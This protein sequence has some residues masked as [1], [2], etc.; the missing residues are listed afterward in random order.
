MKMEKQPSKF[1]KPFVSAPPKFRNYKL[2]FIDEFVFPANVGVV[3]FFPANRDNNLQ[4]VTKLEKSLERTLTRFYPLAGRYIDENHSVDCSDQGAEYIYAKVNIKLQDILV[5]KENVIFFNEFI[6]SKLGVAY[7]LNNSLLATQVTTFECGG[8]ALGVSATHK[9]VDAST[10]CTFINEWAA[11]N[12]E[13]NETEFKGPGFSSSSLLSAR[14]LSH[15]P[16]QPITDD[17]LNKCIVKK[18][19]F[20][21]SAI[22]NLKVKAI[23]NQKESTRPWSKVQLVSAIIWKALNSV[24]RAIHNC[25]RQSI[26]TQA[27]NLRGKTA[28]LIPENSCGNLWGF[29]ATKA[30]SL[31]TT[32]ELANLLSD[33]I[34]KTIT[35]FSKVD[36]NTEEGQMIVLNSLSP[37]SDLTVAESTNLIFFTS[38][39]KFPFCEADFGF[40]NPTLVAPGTI[41]VKNIVYLMGDAG[42]NGIEAYVSLKPKDIP[43]FKEALENVHAFAI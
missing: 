42:G 33:S 19:A 13:E 27:V 21:E 1:I 7:H 39:C 17:M 10:L 32:E 18:C 28:S 8:V 34:N 38:W 4:F 2:G 25:P 22:L 24:D 6:P 12:R 23:A 5:L 30:T 37:M 43:H 3:L 29:C 16:V 20:S 11:T 36:H 40:G 41:P 26:L 35:N 9:I 14:G 31:E 15:V